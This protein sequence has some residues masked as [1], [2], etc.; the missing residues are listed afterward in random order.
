MRSMHPDRCH[1]SAVLCQ[2]ARGRWSAGLWPSGLVVT[3]CVAGL[4]CSRHFQAAEFTCM[5]GDVACLIDATTTA[6]VHDPS[7]VVQ[8]RLLTEFLSQMPRVSLAD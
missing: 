3:L 7:H 6:E 5:A 4:V 8:S 1:P 2:G